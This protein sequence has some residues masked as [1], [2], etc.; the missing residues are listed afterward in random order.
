MSRISRLVL[1]AALVI[2]SLVVVSVPATPVVADE[3]PP[4]PFQHVMPKDCLPGV[5]SATQMSYPFCH[6]SCPQLPG[7]QWC[8]QEC[9]SSLNCYYVIH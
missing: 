5:T 3:P 6:H 1:L 8:S 4:P 7:L 2:M 9:D